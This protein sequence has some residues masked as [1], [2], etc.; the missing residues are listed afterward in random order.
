MLSAQYQPAALDP[1]TADAL[2]KPT[3]NMWSCSA[4]DIV[5]YMEYMYR[6]LGLLNEE[7]MNVDPV[8]LH[9]W[10]VRLLQLYCCSGE[11]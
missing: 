9:K 6:D 10:L 3:F 7:E 11:K 4:K 5:C 1:V 2:R 8:T